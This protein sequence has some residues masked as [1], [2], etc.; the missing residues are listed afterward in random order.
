MGVAPFCSFSLLCPELQP[1]C[2]PP[3][4]PDFQ[5]LVGQ[6]DPGLF[7]ALSPPP[8]SSEP[9]LKRT[10]RPAARLILVDSQMVHLSR[11][12]SISCLVLGQQFLNQN[13]LSH[14]KCFFRLLTLLRHCESQG[15]V[16]HFFF[17]CIWIKMEINSCPRKK[18]R[19][20]ALV[21]P[22]D[23]GSNPPGD[24]SGCLTSCKW[25]MASRWFSH[26]LNTGI[27]IS[28]LMFVETE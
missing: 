27:R 1:G 21:P 19:F 12:C 9:R 7:A 17:F 2:R 14:K 28:S 23:L 26:V 3:P 24:T 5:P 11:E 16:G 25:F 13:F 22:G 8:L 18:W 4:H 20:T 15:N 6:K 10:A